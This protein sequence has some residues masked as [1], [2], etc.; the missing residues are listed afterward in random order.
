MSIES[1]DPQH[2]FPDKSLKPIKTYFEKSPYA[3]VHLMSDYSWWVQKLT[4]LV[5]FKASRYSEAKRI[6]ESVARR[7]IEIESLSR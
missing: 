2:S 6:R 1:T 3:V 5:W 4:T 7:C